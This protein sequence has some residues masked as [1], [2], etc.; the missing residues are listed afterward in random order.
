MGRKKRE[1]RDIKGENEGRR[2][3]GKKTIMT[4]ED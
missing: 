1:G 2:G 4:A 3:G